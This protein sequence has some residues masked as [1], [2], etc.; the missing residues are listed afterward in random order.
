MH[1]QQ[2]LVMRQKG[3]PTSYE[4]VGKDKEECIKKLI[5]ATEALEKYTREDE[6]SPKEKAVQK[7][8]EAGVHTD[9]D[10]ESIISQVFQLYSNILMEK[11]RRP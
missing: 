5:K 8:T 2:A 4:N 3:L 9:E 1:L 10:V 6:N 11:A 7:A